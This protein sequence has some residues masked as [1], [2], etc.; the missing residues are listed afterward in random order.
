MGFIMIFSDMYMMDIDYSQ[1]LYSCFYFPFLLLSPFPIPHSGFPGTFMSFSTF[2]LAEETCQAC[3]WEVVTSLGCGDLAN[4]KRRKGEK[5]VMIK[6]EVD[7]TEAKR[8]GPRPRETKR[9]FFSRIIKADRLLAKLTKREKRPSL[10]Q[11][12]MK[13][14]ISQKTLLKSREWLVHSWEAAIPVN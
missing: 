2:H 9:G 1:C 14:V 12:E 10:I 4:L 8:T 5:I 3:L 7:E 11:L 6:A 13:K